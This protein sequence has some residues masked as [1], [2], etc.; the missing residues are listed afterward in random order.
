MHE[1]VGLAFFTDGRGRTVA[2]QDGNVV[3]ER[4]QFLFDSLEQLRCVATGQVPAADTTRKENIT[5]DQQIL[6]AQEKAKTAR[7]MAGDFEN[8]K[9]C[10]EKLTFRGFLNEKIGRDRFQVEAKP[11]VPEE[12]R[13]RDHGRGIRVATYGAI[14]FLLNF[15]DIHHVIDVS[16]GQDKKL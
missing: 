12:I 11:K 6:R 3:T 14:K 2:G 16:V 15:R 7:A 10:P 1:W 13:I 8:L 5:P 9:F 4:E